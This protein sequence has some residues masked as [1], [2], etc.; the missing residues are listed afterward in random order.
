MMERMTRRNLVLLAT[1]AGCGGNAP[2]PRRY[3]L[4]GEVKLLDP[5]AK[6]ATIAHGRIGDWMG[7]M[8]MEFPVKPDSEFQKL[9]AGDRIE[10]TVVVSDL[11]YYVTD[12]KVAPKP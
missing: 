5:A 7:A 3:L 4:Q 6:T 11:S 12:V 8:T 9:H 1:L 2:K 10:A